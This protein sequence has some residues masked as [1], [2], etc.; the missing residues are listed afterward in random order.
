MSSGPACQAF[1]KTDAVFDAIVDDIGRTTGVQAFGAG[2]VPVDDNLVTLTVRQAWKGVEP[3]RL[4]VVTSE[5]SASCGY[6]FKVGRRYLVFAFKN[7]ADGQWRVS[8]CSAT[9]EFNGSGEDSAFLASLAQPA[10][11]GRVFGTVET[12][13]QQFD[14]GHSTRRQ[15]VEATLHLRGAGKE[16]TAR[17]TNGTFQF[18][19]LPLDTFS[20]DIDA[21]KGFAAE[22]SSRHIELPD[23]RACSRELYVLRAAAALTGRLLRHDRNPAARIEIQLTTPFA[24]GAPIIG[25]PSMSASTDAD[26]FFSI[27]GIPAG[28]YVVGVNLDDLPSD[29]RPYG[30]TLFPSDGGPARVFTIG[31]EPIDIGSWTLPPPL[32][33]VKLS[34]VAVWDD[35]TPAAGVYVGVWDVTGNRPEAARGAGGATTDASGRFQIN[36]REG[37]TYTFAAR[38]NTGPLLKITGPRIEI[39]SDPPAPVRLLIAR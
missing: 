7:R 31:S 8:L 5:F 1:W 10:G 39:G 37:R 21:P 23:D 22:I 9:H 11:G 13:I 36:V 14:P 12:W 2:A 19:G 28:D 35:G 16:W 34:G 20:L 29:Y 17:S 30:R 26:G 33:V 27:S 3:G 25:V 18:T 38:R 24:R 4:Q 32:P 6:D 15:N